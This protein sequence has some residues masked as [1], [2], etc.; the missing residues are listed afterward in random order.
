MENPVPKDNLKNIHIKLTAFYF[1]E[2]SVTQLQ[3]FGNN[4]EQ[5][6]KLAIIQD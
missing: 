6:L 2:N 5:D 1:H 4:S 3:I